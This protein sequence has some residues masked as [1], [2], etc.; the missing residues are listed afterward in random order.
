MQKVPRLERGS[1][2]RPGR[3]SAVCVD[4]DG[5]EAS[6][7]RNE[8]YVVLAD[9]DAE[10]N[11]DIRIVGESG[12]DYLFAAIASSQSTFPRRSKRARASDGWHGSRDDPAGQ[13]I[14]RDVD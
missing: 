4:N 9:K 14:G 12:E 8:I 6:L 11:G 7:E 1:P 10:R 5:Y 13:A 2:P 3:Q